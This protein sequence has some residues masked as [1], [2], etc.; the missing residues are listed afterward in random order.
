MSESSIND[1]Q[2]LQVEL[3]TPVKENVLKVQRTLLQELKS[4][5]L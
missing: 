1:K 4:I 2:V 3:E 5:T